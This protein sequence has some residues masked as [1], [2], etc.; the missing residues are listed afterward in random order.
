MLSPLALAK[1]PVDAQSASPSLL[2]QRVAQPGFIQSMRFVS[3]HF[4]AETRRRRWQRQ[5]KTLRRAS[6]QLHHH[7]R[8]CLSKSSFSRRSI[9]TSPIF[10]DAKRNKTA[11][12]PLTVGEQL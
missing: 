11:T 12:V 4:G 5:L 6:Q 7:F 9:F 2:G 1:F 8:I 10:I 3:A